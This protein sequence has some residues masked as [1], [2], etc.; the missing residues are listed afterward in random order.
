[1][2][3]AHRAPPLAGPGYRGQEPPPEGLPLVH[4]GRQPEDAQHLLR[5]AA[6]AYHGLRA[7]VRVSDTGRRSLSRAGSRGSYGLW[8]LQFTYFSLEMIEIQ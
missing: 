1:M 2:E 3:G 5:P 4:E 7:Q 8:Q 6:P